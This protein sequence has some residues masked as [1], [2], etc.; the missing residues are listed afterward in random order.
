[1]EAFG[2]EVIVVPSLGK[3]ISPALIEKMKRLAYEKVGNLN[4]FYA[5]QFGSKDVVLGYQPMG[6]EI[7]DQIQ[8]NIDVL[9]ASVGHLWVRLTD[10]I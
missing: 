4:G 7:F 6:I 10:L 3:G 9:C 8:G 1:M 5:D 2:A